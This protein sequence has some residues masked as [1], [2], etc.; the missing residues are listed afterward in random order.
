[1]G[2]PS[3]IG[4]NCLISPTRVVFWGIRRRK[5]SSAICIWLSMAMSDIMGNFESPLRYILVSGLNVV[6][7][8]DLFKLIVTVH[9]SPGKTDRP[10]Q[11][12]GSGL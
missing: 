1:M 10:F 9:V 11:H 6:E 7:G 2:N 3:G 12:D 5:F 4:K 8:L